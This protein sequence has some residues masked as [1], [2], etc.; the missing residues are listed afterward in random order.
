[1]LQLAVRKFD[2]LKSFFAE[3]PCINKM[4]RSMMKELPGY[5]AF[6]HICW[7]YLLNIDKDKANDRTQSNLSIQISKTLCNPNNLPPSFKTEMQTLIMIPLSCSGI[8]IFKMILF[9]NVQLK[10]IRSVK[11]SLFLSYT[12]IWG[13][14]KIII[15]IL[16]AADT[17]NKIIIKAW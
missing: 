6:C 13:I 16:Q 1:M 15:S 14:F 10:K 12:D 11:I 2:S 7:F 17:K 3:Y 5:A 9:W 4:N 8:L